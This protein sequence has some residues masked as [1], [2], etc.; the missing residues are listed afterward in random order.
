MT[1]LQQWLLSVQHPSALH[2]TIFSNG[3]KFHPVSNFTELHA[4][5]LASHSYALLIPGYHALPITSLTVIN[6]D[7]IQVAQLIK[8]HIL[9]C[10]PH[11]L[12]LSVQ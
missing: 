7:A 5:T 2:V 9:C 8:T 4:L 6:G 3:S 11:T 10:K 12:H 1:C